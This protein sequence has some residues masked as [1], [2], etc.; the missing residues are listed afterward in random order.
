MKRYLIGFLLLFAS[1]AMAQ[2]KLCVVRYLLDPTDYNV[3]H[4][5]ERNAKIAE[6]LASKPLP[7]ALLC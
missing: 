5:T 1:S 2:E 3:T 7:T 4:S 6:E